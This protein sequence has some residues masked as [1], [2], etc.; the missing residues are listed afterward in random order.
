[1]KE[2][3]IYQVL[4]NH[5]NTLQDKG[6]I[7]VGVFLYGSQNYQLDHERSD[8]DTQAIVLPSLNDIIVER[9]S[10]STTIEMENNLCDVK[11]VR[12]LFK[13]LRAQR[14]NYIETL[15][16]R[17][18]ILNPE[19]KDIYQTVLDHAEDIARY[20]THRHVKCM[21]GMAVNN[22]IRICHRLTVAADK[23]SKCL[24][25]IFRMREM[26]ERYINGE[27]YS[28]VLIPGD[29][30][31]LLTMK[32]NCGLNVSDIK[33]LAQELCEELE[34]LRDQYTQQTPRHKNAEIE[35]LLTD[36]LTRLIRK[37]L[38]IEM[39]ECNGV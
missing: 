1:M 23:P 14:V 25:H 2:L 24:H 29:L 34:T 16:T 17:Y 20:D 37:S 32:R 12:T 33:Q 19:Y 39:E 22:Y 35:N 13:H 38:K 28:D 18:Y 36:V 21:Y 3:D 26:A 11:D 27:N 10:V 4:Q 8:V 9:E 7:V 31:Y 15:F 5:Y 30:T 6:Y